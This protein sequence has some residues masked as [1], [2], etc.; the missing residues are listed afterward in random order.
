MCRFVLMITLLLFSC[1]CGS[2]REIYF[3]KGED[4]IKIKLQFERYVKVK[5]EMSNKFG[6]IDKSKLKNEKAMIRG[7]DLIKS[8]EAETNIFIFSLSDGLDSLQ[9]PKFDELKTLRSELDKRKENYQLKIST[10]VSVWTVEGRL[11][12]ITKRLDL[13]EKAIEFEELNK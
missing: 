5:L 4:K 6:N 8:T 10:G 2:D 9:L 1:N 13:F 3:Y 11:N 12:E 7:F